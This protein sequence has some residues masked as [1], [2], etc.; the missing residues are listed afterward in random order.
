M[1][2]TTG[3]RVL[4]ISLQQLLQG[5]DD[6]VMIAGSE[7]YNQS[8]VFYNAVKEAARQDIP[9]AKAIY[10]DLKTRFPGRPSSKKAE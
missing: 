1:K 9:G 8:L 2:D 4:E 7:A 5:V 6:T 3:L 10:D